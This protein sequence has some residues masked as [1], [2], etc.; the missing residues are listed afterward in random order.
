MVIMLIG[1]IMFSGRVMGWA[2]KLAWANRT[3]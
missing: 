1:G 2:V 3:T